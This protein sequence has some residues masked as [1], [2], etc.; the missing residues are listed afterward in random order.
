MKTGDRICIGGGYDCDSPL[1]RGHLQGTVI[2]FVPGYEPGTP[3]AVVR[4]DAPISF[5]GVTG[6]ILVLELRYQ[7][8][9]W[10]Q[11]TQPGSYTVGVDLYSFSPERSMA[12]AFPPR[13]WT[14]LDSHGIIEVSS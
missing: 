13:G 10:D 12:G 5:E 9:S 11:E 2:D 6:E 7:G 4:L 1:V 8:A 3:A 14:G